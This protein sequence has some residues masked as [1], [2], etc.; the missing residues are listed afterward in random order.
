MS[1]QTSKELLMLRIRTLFLAAFAAV[2]VSS[3]A[4]AQAAQSVVIN[5]DK[6]QS[7]GLSLI[8]VP[9]SWAAGVDISAG[10]NVSLGS[11]TIDPQWDLKSNRTVTI[12]AYFT[13]DLTGAAADGSPTIPVTAFQGTKQVG[14]GAS[15]AISWAG[16]GVAN[17]VILLN[18]TTGPGASDL[19]RTLDPSAT[20]HDVTF[21]LSVAVPVGAYPSTYTTTLTI[22]TFT[23]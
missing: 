11:L 7:I 8:S 22:R 12:D 16:P 17:A 5:L 2:T 15:S 10:G 9:A 20:S 6:Q 14:A 3:A 19:P 18:G 23:S 21:G 4:S 13:Q 1:A